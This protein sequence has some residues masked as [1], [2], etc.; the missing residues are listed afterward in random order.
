MKRNR[1][2][3]ALVGCAAMGVSSLAGAQTTNR[4]DPNALQP[5]RAREGMRSPMF[6]TV[7]TVF[8]V[9]LAVVGVGFMP[10]KRGHQ[11]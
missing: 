9:G 3:W 11:D 2:V 6:M 1:I 8:V 4:P 7:A 10:S 5:P